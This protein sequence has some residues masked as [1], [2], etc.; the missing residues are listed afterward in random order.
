MEG[1]NATSTATNRISARDH[2]M[3][4]RMQFLYQGLPSNLFLSVCLAVF[5]SLIQFEVVGQKEIIW[6]NLLIGLSLLVRTLC[7]FFWINLQEIYKPSLWVTTYRIGIALSGLAWASAS[8]L[9]FPHHDLQ[10]QIILVMTVVVMSI[11][12]LY[13]HTID[14]TSSLVFVTLAT[15]PTLLVFCLSSTALSFGIASLCVSAIAF[16]IYG[17]GRSLQHLNYLLLRNNAL[18]KDIDDFKDQ[19]RMEKTSRR[20]LKHQEKYN[21]FTDSYGYLLKSAMLFTQSTYGF[22]VKVSEAGGYGT[23]EAIIDISL[24]TSTLSNAITVNAASD[25]TRYESLITSFSQDPCTQIVNN[26]LHVIHTFDL[27]A[28]HPGIINS[29]AIPLFDKEALL[30]VMVLCNASSGFQ[31]SSETLI[32]PLLRGATYLIERHN[33]HI[34]NDDQDIAFIYQ[35]LAD[36]TSLGIIGFSAAGK[37]E[38]CNNAAQKMLGISKRESE[39][40]SITSFFDGI[41]NSLH[42]NSSRNIKPDTKKALMAKRKNGTTFYCEYE[43]IPLT[44]TEKTLTFLIFSDRSKEHY[45]QSVHRQLLT[46]IERFSSN[47]IDAHQRSSSSDIIQHLKGIQSAAHIL[48]STGDAQS[49][50]LEDLLTHLK[51]NVKSIHPEPLLNITAIAD[52]SSTYLHGDQQLIDSALFHL[53]MLFYKIQP[54]GSSIYMTIGTWH[55]HIRITVGCETQSI[56]K[57]TLND[58]LSKKHSSDLFDLFLVEQLLSKIGVVLHAVKHQRDLQCYME[59]SLAPSFLIA[60]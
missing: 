57:K 37:I 22:L 48:Q 46:M 52:P 11:I 15:L 6:W 29:I 41:L 35:Y 12:T 60:T 47:L 21:S 55:E 19:E 56:D 38:H 50:Q 43:D 44:T 5:I 7:W 33:R 45:E 20:A 17:S 28:K 36:R 40:T 27:P 13:S 32:A 58:I 59:L 49:F 34:K 8:I 9:L 23:C 51:D 10:H 53:I 16:A 18:K 3:M 54:K 39:N 30:G 1:A 42:K 14:R 4:N 31:A 24:P 25:D 26:H 2:M